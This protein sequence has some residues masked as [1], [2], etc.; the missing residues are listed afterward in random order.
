MQVRQSVTYSSID[1]KSLHDWIVKA[2]AKAQITGS[3]ILLSYSQNWECFNPLLLLASK[4]EAQQPKF[5]WEQPNADLVLAAAGSV[6]EVSVPNHDLSDRFDCAKKFIKA[7][8][9][10]AIIAKNSNFATTESPI[11][12]H[13]FGAFSFYRNGS[14]ASD[15]LD[16]AETNDYQPVIEFP[17]LLFFIPRWMVR[18]K[19][20]NC[21]LTLNHYIQPWDK[22]D[23]VLESIEVLRSHLQESSHYE[24]PTVH[25]VS[26]IVEVQGQQIWTEIVERALAL[27]H[28][29]H[30]EKVVLARALDVLADRNFDPFQVLHV[31]R[32]EYPECISFLLDYGVGKT[33]LGATPEVVLQFKAQS[34]RLWLRS[35]AVA[36]SIERGKTVQ[37]D[38]MLG[39]RLL[40]SEKDMREHQIVIRSICDRLQSMGAAIDPQSETS[41]LRLS[42]VQHL[43]TPITAQ[44]D[45]P[46]WLIALDILQ[47]LH[48]TAAVGGEPRDRAVCFMQQWE[49]CDRGWYA[50][51]IGW[52][53]GDGEGT[54]G[55]GIRAGYIQ[56]DRARI[57]A[58]AGIVANSQVEN[59]QS[60]T[61]IKF[62]ALLK[63]LGAM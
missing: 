58:G 25:E 62:A 36:G 39:D 21:T 37:E 48:P 27:I 54:F 53:N 14:D 24:A 8:L 50:A 10:N 17:T 38:L 3:P 29:G 11:S 12:I 52:L 55:V 42:N 4:S 5:Y 30:F 47:Q 34:D 23:E 15:Y 45:D 31:L 7:H 51:P 63:A 41:L 59:E 20:Q 61:T 43:Y 26:K 40:N 6:A 35:D 2:I 46:D 32:C 33:F 56:G 60:E 57:F 49:A 1:S 28:Q 13:I 44:I 9:T 18:H 22:P 19:E 16:L